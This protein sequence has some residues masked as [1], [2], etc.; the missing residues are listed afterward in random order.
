MSLALVVRLLI[1]GLLEDLEEI[2]HRAAAR[3]VA[4][5]EFHPDLVLDGRIEEP[6]LDQVLHE[7]GKDP[8]F[9]VKLAG[10]VLVFLHALP[11]I[12]QETVQVGL[13]KLEVLGQVL[14]NT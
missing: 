10:V 5:A 4:A 12:D 14:Y 2:G 11:E 1:A 9:W 7:S 13:R 6:L 3:S 8:H